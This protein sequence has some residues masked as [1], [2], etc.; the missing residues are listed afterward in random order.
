MHQVLTEPELI[1]KVTSDLPQ[2]HKD[3]VKVLIVTTLPLNIMQFAKQEDPQAVLHSPA[4]RHVWVSQAISVLIM[5]TLGQTAV[6]DVVVSPRNLASEAQLHLQMSVGPPVVESMLQVGHQDSPQILLFCNVSVAGIRM[7]SMRSSDARGPIDGWCWCG[8]ENTEFFNAPV[9]IFQKL[10][11][12]LC[13]RMFDE[14]EL[15]PEEEEHML[16]GSIV[17]LSTKEQRFASRAFLERWL[18]IE[19]THFSAAMQSR[20]PCLSSIVSSTGESADA[21]MLGEPCGTTRYCVGCEEVFAIL[22]SVPAMHIVCPLVARVLGVGLR[23]WTNGS[24]DS[25]IVRALNTSVHQCNAQCPRNPNA[26][27]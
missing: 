24:V 22:S 1:T 2:W 19:E 6:I 26:G 20:Y 17:H 13:I 10:P 23:D 25:W 18:G 14:R 8:G 3:C 4:A 9:Y 12:L 27:Q 7:V 21:A 15:S 11:M 5:T 16:L